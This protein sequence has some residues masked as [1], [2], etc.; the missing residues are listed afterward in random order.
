MPQWSPIAEPEKELTFMILWFMAVLPV[1]YLSFR[2]WAQLSIE[3]YFPQ[4]VLFLV[5]GFG[6][7]T[8]LKA[9]SLGFEMLDFNAAFLMPLV[10]ALPWTAMVTVFKKSYITTKQCTALLWIFVPM[11]L[12]LQ[13]AFMYLPLFALAYYGNIISAV[14]LFSIVAVFYAGAAWRLTSIKNA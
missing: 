1:V 10:W 2:R 5:I 6:I 7:Q 4:V 3:S 8:A 13:F 9:A 14:S 12:S 11:V